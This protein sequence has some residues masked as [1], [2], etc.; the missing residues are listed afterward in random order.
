[1]KSSDLGTDRIIMSV[2]AQVKLQSEVIEEL[3]KNICSVLYVDNLDGEPVVTFELPPKVRVECLSSDELVRLEHLVIE[4]V[5]LLIHGSKPGT[6][7]LT[8]ADM[9]LALDVDEELTDCYERVVANPL[10]SREFLKQLEESAML[11]M[12]KTPGRQRVGL[13]LSSSAPWWADGDVL[14]EFFSSHNGIPANLKDLGWI[15]SMLNRNPRGLF[16]VRKMFGK[17]WSTFHRQPFYGMAFRQLVLRSYFT[18][19][20]V[21]PNKEGNSWKYELV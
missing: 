12:V 8:L 3:E 13:S 7:F 15:Q 20:R 10:P 6:F 19:I 18:N 16:T 14:T 21:T 5:K 9:E 17:H 11:R 1:M 4:Q 2:G